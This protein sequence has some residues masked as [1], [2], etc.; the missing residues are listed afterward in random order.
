[1]AG[2]LVPSVHQN[3]FLSL[4][5]FS[6]KPRQDSNPRSNQLG[7]TASLSGRAIPLAPPD[8]STHRGSRRIW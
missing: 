4:R 3:C 6:G 5:Q 7:S 2:F 1:M 8:L